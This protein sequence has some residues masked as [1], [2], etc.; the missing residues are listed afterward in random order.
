[1]KQFS[2]NEVYEARVVWCGIG[3]QRKTEELIKY[4]R[5]CEREERGEFTSTI[6][7]FIYQ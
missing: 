1:M 3:E 2:F 5:A 4:L 6:R 7:K